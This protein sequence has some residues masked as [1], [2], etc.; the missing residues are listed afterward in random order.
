MNKKNFNIFLSGGIVLL[1]AAAIGL[2]WQTGILD[3]QGKAEAILVLISIAMAFSLT[4]LAREIAGK[5]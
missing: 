2:I 3:H 5:K 1:L 4:I